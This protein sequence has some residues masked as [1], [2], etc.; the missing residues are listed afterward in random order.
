LR[1]EPAAGLAVMLLFHA[2]SK[3]AMRR[4]LPV[5]PVGTGFD[6]RYNAFELLF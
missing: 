5:L 3:W 6:W 1:R 4:E 2:L